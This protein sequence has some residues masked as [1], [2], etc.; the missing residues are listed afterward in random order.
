MLEQ[1]NRIINAYLRMLEDAERTYDYCI[2]QGKSQ[3]EAAE[4][5]C[6]LKDRAKEIYEQRMQAV[7]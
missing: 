3:E 2:E 5:E 4:L 7:K 1:I 6:Y